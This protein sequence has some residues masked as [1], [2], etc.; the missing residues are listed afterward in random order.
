M[1]SHNAMNQG[2]KHNRDSLIMEGHNDR[3]KMTCI[4]GFDQ[5]KHKPVCHRRVENYPG[6]EQKG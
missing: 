6:I 1:K 5:V 3:D 4:R 2:L